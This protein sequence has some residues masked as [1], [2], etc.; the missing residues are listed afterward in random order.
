MEGGAGRP[1]APSCTCLPEVVKS[2]PGLKLRNCWPG[3][4]SSSGGSGIR[5]LIEE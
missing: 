3:L 2:W 4:K 1:V 5:R